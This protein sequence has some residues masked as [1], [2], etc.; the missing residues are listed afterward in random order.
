M[1]KQDF[2]FAVGI[3]RCGIQ[4]GGDGSGVNGMTLHTLKVRLLAAL[5]GIEYRVHSER[6]KLLVAS[7][8]DTHPNT[9]GLKPFAAYI[10][11]HAV[12]L[13]SFGPL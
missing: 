8:L 7:M 3:R 13:S 1:E 12:L 9:A 10:R 5:N 11:A 2:A 6:S 4:T